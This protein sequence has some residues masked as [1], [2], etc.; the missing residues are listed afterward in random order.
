[1]GKDEGSGTVRLVIASKGTGKE[2]EGHTEYKAY[3]A[4]THSTLYTVY[5]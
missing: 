1:M 4:R 2:T 5:R 3:K